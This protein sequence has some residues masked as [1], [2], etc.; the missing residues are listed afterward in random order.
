MRCLFHTIILSLALTGCTGYP[1]GLSEAE[2]NAL[3][4]EKRVELREKQTKINAHLA[5]KRS[6]ENAARYRLEAAKTEKELNVA[7]ATATQTSQMTSVNTSPHII[8]NNTNQPGKSTART[9]KPEQARKAAYVKFNHL[10][11]MGHQ[12]RKQHHYTAAEKYYRKASDTAPDKNTKQLAQ[13]L[14]K[15]TQS[16]KKTKQT[17]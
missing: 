4:L 2:W 15:A 1:M 12:A 11:Q 17:G 13:M 5:E 14:V 16:L 10:I 3:P 7:T 6:I 8:V 9:I